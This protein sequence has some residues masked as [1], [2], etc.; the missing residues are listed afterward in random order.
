MKDIVINKPFNEKMKIK[1]EKV[2]EKIRQDKQ[3]EKTIK[4]LLKEQK[5]EEI[6][7]L[8]GKDVYVATV[9]EKYL[10]KFIKEY[11]KLSL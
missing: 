3:K 5:Y 1:F 11:L 7:N 8:Y 2:K 9:P 6:Y 4:G 10:K